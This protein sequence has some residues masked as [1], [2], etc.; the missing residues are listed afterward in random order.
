MLSGAKHLDFC[1][2]RPIA[3]L[4]GSQVTWRIRLFV[5]VQA[6]R[7]TILDEVSLPLSRV[8]IHALGLRAHDEIESGQQPIRRLLYGEQQLVRV[9]PIT[10][11]L[12]H[13]GEEQ[14]GG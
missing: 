12:G 5:A 3:C 2:K 14:L 11:V 6:L 8:C 9:D 1:P 7:V 13:A 10:F 4:N